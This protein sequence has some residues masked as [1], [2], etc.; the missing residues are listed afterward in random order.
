MKAC[1]LKSL[2]H[3]QDA[4][5]QAHSSFV[6]RLHNSFGEKLN[7]PERK[8]KKGPKDPHLSGFP[9]NKVCL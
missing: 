7:S 6:E 2:S 1:L 9:E 3:V 5:G 4:N 8:K